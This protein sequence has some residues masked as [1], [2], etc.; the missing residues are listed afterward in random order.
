[1]LYA[2]WFMHAK[3]PKH[4]RDYINSRMYET[5]KVEFIKRLKVNNKGEKNAFFGKKHS[6]LTRRKI[7]LLL[8]GDGRVE[9]LYEY[10]EEKFNKLLSKPMVKIEKK[11]PINLDFDSVFN[12]LMGKPFVHI[13]KK[14]PKD[15]YLDCILK[16]LKGLPI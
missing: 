12:G 13:E 6:V 10:F 4:S 1:M 3:G 7:S 11:E 16:G 2:F 15:L 14:T 9:G 8:G 5:L